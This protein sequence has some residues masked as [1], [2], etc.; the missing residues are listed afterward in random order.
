MSTLTIND[1]E[2]NT[3]Y[4]HI[5]C[6]AIIGNKTKV[7]IDLEQIISIVKDKLNQGYT[8]DKQKGERVSRIKPK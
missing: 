3:Y 5:T 1:I 8:I 2:F 7:K 6:Y 4:G